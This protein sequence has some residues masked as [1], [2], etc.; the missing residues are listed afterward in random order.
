MEK[1]F[2]NI[3]IPIDVFFEDNNYPLVYYSAAN[4]R[5]TLDLSKPQNPH[6]LYKVLLW[7]F[8]GP[9]VCQ[10]ISDAIYTFF[11]NVNNKLIIFVMGYQY[12]WSHTPLNDKIN[13]HNSFKELYL[14]SKGTQKNIKN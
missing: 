9:G 2:K 14:E 8:G 10:K 5:L 4:S 1:L 6:G 13:S 7:T 12:I 3:L 11:D